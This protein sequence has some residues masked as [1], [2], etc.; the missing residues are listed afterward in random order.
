MKSISIL[1]G[2]IV[3]ISCIKLS[4]KYVEC[5]K[6]KDRVI[7][8]CNEETI[9]TLTYKISKIS[10]AI[11]SCIDTWNHEEEICKYSKYL[12]ELSEELL[13]IDSRNSKRINEIANDIYLIEVIVSDIN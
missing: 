7:V 3:I 13:Y 2:L 12:L 6:D 4:I 9:S 1:I 10:G 8:A 11:Y 5:Q